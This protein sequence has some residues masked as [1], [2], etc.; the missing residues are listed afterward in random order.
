MKKIFKF[1]VS[2]LFVFIEMKASLA[3]IDSNNL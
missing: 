3:Y 1:W 2:V